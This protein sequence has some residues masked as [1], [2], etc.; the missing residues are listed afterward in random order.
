MESII[1]KLQISILD[2]IGNY[3]KDI[4]GIKKEMEMIEESFTKVVPEL[5]KKASHSHSKT[6]HKKSSS[7]K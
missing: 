6:T 3:G 5:K 1:D 4:Q 2:K 7:K